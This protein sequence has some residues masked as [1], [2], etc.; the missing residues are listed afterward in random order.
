[1]VG[2]KSQ[3]AVFQVG[4]PLGQCHGDWDALAFCMKKLIGLKVWGSHFC[5]LPCNSL[6]LWPTSGPCYSEY[7]AFSAVV[8]RDTSVTHVPVYAQERDTSVTHVTVYAQERD[9]S[10]THVTVY[11]DEWTRAWHQRDS[12]D[13][14][15]GWVHKSVTPAWLM[16]QFTWMSLQER[17]TSV[18]HVTVYLNEWTR[19]WLTYTVYQFGKHAFPCVPLTFLLSKGRTRFT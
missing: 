5:K 19:A 7:Y 13:S 11:L 4:M 17:D 18:T 14:L 9:T 10:V 16:C 6:C 2:F 3:K 15:P 8:P 1:M 12:C